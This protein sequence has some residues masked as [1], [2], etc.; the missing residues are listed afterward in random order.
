MPMIRRHFFTQRF[1]MRIIYVTASL[2]FGPGEAFIIAEIRELLRRG[3]EVLVVPRSRWGK[4]MHGD[5]EALLPQTVGQPVL[6]YEI[7]R[8]ALYLFWQIP[9][10]ALMALSLLLQTRSP[11]VMLKNLAVYPKGLWLAQIAE[12]W[13]AQHIH[14]H[15]AGTTASVAMVASNI[16]GIPWSFTCHRWDIVE[17]NLLCLKVRAATLARFINQKGLDMATS[18]G[19]K[20]LE[21]K[22]RVIHMEVELPHLPAPA[23]PNNPPPF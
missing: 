8:S 10:R 21:R 13:R 18:M 15:W 23:A 7:L 11:R 9:L 20:G 17:K 22:A 5:A 19:V 14:A 6:S 16:S 2:P 12:Q 4:V 3:H 1:G